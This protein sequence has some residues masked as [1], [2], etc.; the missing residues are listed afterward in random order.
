MITANWESALKII[1][2]A[3]ELSFHFGFGVD[4][5]GVCISSYC[6]NLIQSITEEWTSPLDDPS[7]HHVV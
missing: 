5:E 2:S 6:M 4:I 7:S 3:L 1:D